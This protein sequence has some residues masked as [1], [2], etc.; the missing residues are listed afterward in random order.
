MAPRFVTTCLLA[1][2][3]GLEL[4]APVAATAQGSPI[5]VVERFH[6]ELLS[7]M[8]NART[9]GYR[10]RYR[11]L[12]PAIDGTFHLPAMTRLVAG[13]GK[14]KSFSDGQKQ[15]FIDAFSRMTM[16]TYAHRFDGYSGESFQT[17][18]AVPVRSKTV[19]VKASVTKGDGEVIHLNYL[20]RRFGS[21]WR[22]IDVFLKGTIS[23][24]ATRRSEYSSVLRRSR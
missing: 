5:A 12:A 18:E 20:L 13:R 1:G 4:L 6:T 7:V 8:K 23:E 24:L 10:G 21:G 15:A 14:W 9:L 22:V 19:L 11:V 3:I 17:M 2:W 16:A